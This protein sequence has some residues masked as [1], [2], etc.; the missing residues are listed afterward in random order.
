MLSPLISA[1][2]P[3]Y[4]DISELYAFLI[5]IVSRFSDGSQAAA[6]VALRYVVFRK[7]MSHIR[8]KKLVAQKK[9]T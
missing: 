1:V 4:D 3:G 5:L 7:E 2:D 8:A 6:P 9:G